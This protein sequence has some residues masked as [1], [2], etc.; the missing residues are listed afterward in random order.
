MV[1]FPTF[2][3]VDRLKLMCES[4]MLQSIS[5]E[6]A[7][8]ILMAADAHHAR[9]LRAKCLSFVLKNFDEVSRTKAMEEVVLAAPQ[10]VIEILKQR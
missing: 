9:G 8:F 7:A 4:C 6:N 2:A 3:H 5:T 10:L 1:D